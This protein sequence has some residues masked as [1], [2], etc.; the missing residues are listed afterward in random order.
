VGATCGKAGDGTACGTE[1]A[2]RGGVTVGDDTVWAAG[3]GDDAGSGD[4][5]VGG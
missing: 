3:S 1:A 2:D 4:T 5:A